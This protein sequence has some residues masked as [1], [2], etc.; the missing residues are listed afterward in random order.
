ME[1][2]G[3]G[4]IPLSYEMYKEL[5]SLVE[6]SKAQL[7]YLNDLKEEND[8]WIKN[9]NKLE[10]STSALGLKDNEDEVK[11]KGFRQNYVTRAYMIDEAKKKAE[12]IIN[13]FNKYYT[14]H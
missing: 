2:I 11:F 4:F 10:E 6:I 8:E 12:W 7:K 14:I 5:E 1:K 13:D 9:I 3:N